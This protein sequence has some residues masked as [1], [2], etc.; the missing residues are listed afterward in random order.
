MLPAPRSFL[1][2]ASQRFSF[3]NPVNSRLP[4]PILFCES[5]F[6]PTSYKDLSEVFYGGAP[7][8]P[9]VVDFT[10]THITVLR[11]TDP[12][13]RRCTETID[14]FVPDSMPLT[15]C[16]NLAAG[17]TVMP[18]R[19][20]GPE[21][22]HRCLKNSP[23]N[24]KHYF[25]GASEDCL[26]DLIKETKSL[27][28]QLNICGSHHGYFTPDEWPRVLEE[29]NAS[30]PDVIWVGL[31]TPKQQEFTAWA[32]DKV[33]QGWLLNVGF[34]F[35]VNAGRK[36][37]APQWM[38]SMGLTW[39]YR[40]ASEPKRLG[41]RYAKFNSLFLLYALEWFMTNHWLTGLLRQSWLMLLGILATV[42]MFLTWSVV[43]LPTSLPFIGLAILSFVGAWIGVVLAMAASEQEEDEFAPSKK[44]LNI[45]AFVGVIGAILCL[46]LPPLFGLIDPGGRWSM[47][48]AS[49]A[50]SFSAV[51]FL[52]VLLT[53]GSLTG[54]LGTR[55]HPR[56]SLG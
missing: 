48:V 3:S 11:L 24:T 45:A 42:V 17:K 26:A 22:M 27:N 39:L 44:G 33:R 56:N 7:E 43:N 23:P 47:A 14:H 37:D 1:L 53:V 20:Y 16:V 13:F 32:K 40:L 28:P 9:T 54:L 36:S 55:S 29:I 18:D 46:L 35:D 41:P 30:A 10:N 34:A 12:E 25:L 51:A 5:L 2:S 4:N 31:G 8:Q 6:T 38:Q 19:V 50:L 15:W 52:V 49:T 21:F